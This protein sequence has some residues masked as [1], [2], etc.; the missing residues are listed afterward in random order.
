[1]DPC[2]FDER[3]GDMLQPGLSEILILH[4]RKAPPI[5]LKIVRHLRLEKY[6]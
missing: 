5:F 1:M 2:G 3:T 4:L 6:N